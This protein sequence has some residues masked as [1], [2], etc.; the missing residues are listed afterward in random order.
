V[1]AYSVNLVV[2][3]VE[4]YSVN[5]VV[6]VEVEA[7]SVNLVVV[8]VVWVVWVVAEEEKAASSE[9]SEEEE[10]VVWRDCSAVL[11][12]VKVVL[13]AWPLSSVEL[14]QEELQHV[15]PKTLSRRTHFPHNRI[16][17]FNQ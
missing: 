14:H 4:A 6:A 15:W 3:A 1:E 5:L 13:E 16:S 12:V 7:C 11:A 10:V 17:S 2:A 9:S 8:V